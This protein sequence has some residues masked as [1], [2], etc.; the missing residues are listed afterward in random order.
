MEYRKG[1]RRQAVEYAI[2]ATR[3]VPRPM[4]SC[5]L[6]LDCADTTLLAS[7]LASRNATYLPLFCRCVLFCRLVSQ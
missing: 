4:A 6:Q 2:C 5:P 1:Q 3:T 7:W